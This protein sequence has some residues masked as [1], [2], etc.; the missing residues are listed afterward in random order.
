M[1]Q[2]PGIRPAPLRPSTSPVTAAA[3]G[4]WKRRVAVKLSPG[5]SSVSNGTARSSARG[6][7]RRPFRSRR[8]TATRGSRCVTRRARH[9]AA[10][11]AG[12]GAGAVDLDEEAPPAG[13]VLAAHVHGAGAGASAAQEPGGE[14]ELD[15]GGQV[16]DEVAAGAVEPDAGLIVGGWART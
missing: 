6:S 10:G 16:S 2:Q 11:G 15:L 13:R 1:M 8:Y 9:S 5:C 4:T 7:W 3:A 14:P 12:P